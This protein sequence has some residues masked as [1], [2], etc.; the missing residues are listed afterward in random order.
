MTQNQQPDFTALLSDRRIIQVSG[1]DAESFL[2]NIVTNDILGV[3]AAQIRYACLLTPQ[4]AYLHDFFILPDG[5][6][7]YHL[8]C[9]AARS[10]DL[11]RRF[12]I[13]KLRSRVTFADAAGLRV[14]ATT[15][16]GR[17]FADPRR[18]GMGFRLYTAEQI[19]AEP[20]TLYYDFCIERGVPCGS[21]T[22]RP[23]K[24]TMADVSLDLLNAVAW[25]KGCFVGQEVAAR[26]H[27]RGLTKRRLF[28][29]E[30]A[31][32]QPGVL[33]QK[34]NDVG[35][36]R[37]VN[38]TGDKALAVVKLAAVSQ[39]DAELVTAQGAKVRL[40]DA[41]SEIKN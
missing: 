25:D 2:Q 10:D 7:G 24:E 20:V 32:L 21:L 26:M 12:A 16:A 15:Q 27:N 33:R 31:Q 5:A 1:A 3:A 17:G 14:Y 13:F 36:I 28:V 18:A 19:P 9:E 39:K 6:G 22:I 29:V 41:A 4:G 34:D 37:Q 11:L 35:E 40:A 23:E 38:S 8:D 30:G